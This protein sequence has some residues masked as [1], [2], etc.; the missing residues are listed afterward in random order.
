MVPSEHIY[1]QAGCTPVCFS[2]KRILLSDEIA[3]TR[4]LINRGATDFYCISCL[5]DHF[6]VS[7]DTLRQKIKDFRDMGCTLFT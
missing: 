7:E 3:L 2:C 4:K 5:A 1:R 6:Q